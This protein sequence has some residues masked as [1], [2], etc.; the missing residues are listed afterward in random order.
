MEAKTAC[1]M[2]NLVILPVIDVL[3]WLLPTSARL[4]CTTPPGG[5]VASANV[6]VA[7]ME[8]VKP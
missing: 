4:A 2:H 7:I 5:L 6:M 1:P 8:A 3:Q